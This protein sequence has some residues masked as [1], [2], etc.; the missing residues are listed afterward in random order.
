MFYLFALILI[1]CSR[2]CGYENQVFHGLET[3]DSFDKPILS[4]FWPLDTRVVGGSETLGYKVDMAIT[5]IAD[6]SAI[7]DQY[8]GY[9]YVVF[10]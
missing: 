6:K 8:F 5:K 10:Y 7:Y 9:L 4:D 2:S 3:L 1:I